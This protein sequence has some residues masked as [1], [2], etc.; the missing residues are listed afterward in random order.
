MFHLSSSDHLSSRANAI[1]VLTGNVP[2]ILEEDAPTRSD[3]GRAVYASMALEWTPDL[4]R[5]VG[6]RELSRMLCRMRNDISSAAGYWI[7]ADTSARS[8]GERA[9]IRPNQWDLRG[10]PLS[11]GFIC[12]KSR[13][14]SN[15]RP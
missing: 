8:A 13:I 12:M 2:S 11:C 9:L 3:K 14:Y 1:G 7:S 4:A 6:R 5:R 15:G 10:A